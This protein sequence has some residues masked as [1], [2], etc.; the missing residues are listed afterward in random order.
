MI[1]RL[2]FLFPALAPNPAS[3]EYLRMIRE[4]GEQGRWMEWFFL[5]VALLLLVPVFL[6][7]VMGLRDLIRGRKPGVWWI[8][9][10]ALLLSSVGF[11]ISRS[12]A[13][14]LRPYRLAAAE[15]SNY[16]VVEARVVRLGSVRKV[17]PS[18]DSYRKVQW[19]SA[20]PL[21]QTGWTPRLFV[22]GG[23]LFSR[24]VTFPEV[25]LNDVA[26][27]GLDPSGRLPPLFLG[28]KRS[29]SSAGNSK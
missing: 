16:R 2:E 18:Y 20:A 14:P 12:L 8:A 21:A 17:R 3:P 24:T 9:A 4:L 22:S 13:E 23:R 25:H 1:S 7:G 6:L 19:E 27:V 11:V 10:G 28:M 26:Y 15:Y 5:I 29:A